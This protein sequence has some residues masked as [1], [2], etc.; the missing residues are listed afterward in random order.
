M[1]PLPFF[2][3]VNVSLNIRNIL[4]VN[5]KA[6]YISVETTLRMYWRDRR[7]APK[8][9]APGEEYV[10]LNG[11]AVESFWIPDIFVDQAKALRT[12][13]VQSNCYGVFTPR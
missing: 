11:K 8:A 13:S 5:E 6:K 12:P 9:L 4:E 10:S 1:T 2:I 3:Q 7:V